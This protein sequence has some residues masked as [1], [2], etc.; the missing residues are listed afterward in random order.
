MQFAKGMQEV[1]KK[2]LKVW[3]Y[4]FMLSLIDIISYST[5]GREFGCFAILLLPSTL[6]CFATIY[7]FGVYIVGSKTI[8]I[9]IVMLY[10]AIYVYISLKLIKFC[11]NKFLHYINQ[12]KILGYPLR[13]YTS[14][15]KW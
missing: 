4:R 1:R 14:H 3:Y 7:I 15:D 9:I 11:K 2:I 8:T 6:A 13:N 5:L 10:A 12:L